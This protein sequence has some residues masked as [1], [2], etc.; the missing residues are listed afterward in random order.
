MSILEEST[1]AALRPAMGVFNKL[2]MYKQGCAASQ[3]A[4]DRTGPGD[5]LE[6]W[7]NREQVLEAEG[8]PSALVMPRRLRRGISTPRSFIPAKRS[9]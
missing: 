2:V 6:K 7:H 5:Q 9:T 3:P 1:V 4:I 8:M